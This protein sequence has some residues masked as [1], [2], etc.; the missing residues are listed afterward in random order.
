MAQPTGA[1]EIYP[2]VTVDPQIVHGKPVITGT[3]VMVSQ[4]V[5]HLAAGDS[6]ET[7]CNA[8]GLTPEQVR[9]AVVHWHQF[10]A[11]AVRR[12]G[13][14]SCDRANRRAVRHLAARR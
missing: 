1:G 9:A 13:N 10:R 3:R 12:S 8:Y 2:G 6:I 7:V 11:L 14:E 5:G 4:I